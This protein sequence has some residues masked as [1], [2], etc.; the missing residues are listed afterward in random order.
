MVITETEEVKIVAGVS[1]AR[2]KVNSFTLK[3]LDSSGM[4]P[5]PIML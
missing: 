5:F 1:R 2:E 4:G 3:E